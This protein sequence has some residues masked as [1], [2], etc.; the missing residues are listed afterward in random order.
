[1]LIILSVLTLSGQELKVAVLRVAFQPDSSPA[2]TGDGSFV[3]KD[4]VD[5]DCT[6]WSLDPP[7]H[8]RTYFQDHLTAMDYYWQRVSNGAVHVNIA[9]SDIYPL[10]DDDV[11]QLPHDMLYYH[12]YLEDYDETDKLFEL[13][14]DVILLADPDINFDEYTTIILAHAGMGGDF[15]FALDPT[16]G[17]IPSAYLS[18]KDFTEYGNL[19]TD[20]GNLTDLIII[21]ESQNFLQYKETRSLFE[22]A[23]DPCFYQVGLNGTLALMLGF[24]LDL[25]PLYNTETGVSLVG[26]FALMDQGSNNF[27]GIVPAYPDPYTRIEQGWTTANEMYIGDSVSIH[28][29]D[30]PVKISISDSEYYLIENRQR[31]ILHPSSMPLWIDEAGFDTVSVVLS[32][33]GVVLNVDE[34]NAGLPGN[35]LNIWHIDENARFTADNPN[36]GPIQMVDFVEADGAQDMGHTTQLLF[37]SYLETGWWFDPWFAGNEGWFH[38]NRYQEVVGDSLLSFNS[39][40]FP[41]TTSNSGAPTHLNIENISNNGTTM[42]FSISSDRLVVTDFISSIIGWG[43][44]SSS[45]WAF[46]TDSSEV[47]ETVFDQGRLSHTSNLT[48]TPQDILHVNSDSTFQFR[49]PWVFPNMDMGSRFIDMETGIFHS[50]PT[51]H[52]PFEIIARNNPLLTLSF[53]AEE[54]DNF[55]LVKWLE[56]QAQFIS[57]Q[58]SGPPV[59]R[60]Q[61]TSGIQPFYSSFT[62]DPTPVGVTP[63]RDPAGVLTII[64]EEVDVIS[65][66]NGENALR[67]SHLPSDE[68]EYISADK[69]RQIIP[70]D[71]DLDGYYEIALFYKNSIKIINQAGIAYNGNPFSIDAYIGN[72]IVGSTI[73]GQPSIFL[74]HTNGYSIFDFTGNLLDS[75]ILP[76]ESTSIEN[77]LSTSNGLSLILSGQDLLYFEYDQTTE[78]IAFWSDPQGNKS[79]DRVVVTPAVTSV[80]TPAIKFRSAYNYPNPIKGSTTTIRA[81]L[82]DV[83]TWSIEIF[84]MSGAQVARIEQDVLQQHSYNE[85]LWDA[86]DVSNGVYLAQIV[87]GNSSEIIKIA[88]IR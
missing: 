19:E 87:A 20:E 33:G 26:G 68:M 67:I 85:W 77:Y 31:N 57:E 84:S 7:P 65:W 66:S 88:V 14:E 63:Y 37:A 83:D 64:P 48:V 71:A 5:L 9:E 60:F 69:P 15:A 80:S 82:G 1:M 36:G 72:P 2:T 70:L 81:W 42:S 21:P 41:A 34:Q 10:N 79:G 75:G 74:R 45:L 62:E 25:P 44:A 46:N 30:P 49:Y 76:Q 56:L 61:T 16:P 13:S 22:D 3:L 29:D 39:G 51:K 47:I 11:Y 40:T 55:Y 58:L 12:P 59:A 52:K 6:D 43:T 18:Q 35:G 38:I 23:E 4:T 78:G 32:T 73:E 53:F 17:N 8:G 24:H 27:H 86:S 28:V 50:H 54:S